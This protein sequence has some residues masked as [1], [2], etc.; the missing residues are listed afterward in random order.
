MIPEFNDEGNLPA[1]VHG[2][3][4]EE[5]ATRFERETELGSA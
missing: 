4:L 1:G 5:I 2:A 3:S